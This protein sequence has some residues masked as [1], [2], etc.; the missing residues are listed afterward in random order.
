MLGGPKQ[1][2]V[3]VLSVKID[4]AA[5]ESAEIGHRGEVGTDEGPA[6]APGDELAPQRQLP[7]LGLPSPLFEIG[8]EIGAAGHV[9]D[10]LDR[11]ALLP[12][13]RLIASRALPQEQGEGVDQNRLSRPRLTGQHGESGEELKGDFSDEDQV[14]NFEV[15]E[16]PS[17]GW[18]EDRTLSDGC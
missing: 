16:H 1:R 8:K 3:L 4:E 5:S 13:T 6:P 2:L 17:L 10:R 15:S 18:G 11:A 14:A 12:P 9:E 7:L